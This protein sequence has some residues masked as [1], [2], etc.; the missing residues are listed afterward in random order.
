[1]KKKHESELIIKKINKVVEKLVIKNN[2]HVHDVI[3]WIHPIMYRKLCCM[4]TV[5]NNVNIGQSVVEFLKKNNAFTALTG[6]NLL[7]NSTE[8]HYFGN[9]CSMLTI[10]D[11]IVED[12]QFSREQGDIALL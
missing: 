11:I 8:H 1:M 5:I 7:I 4:N 3:L 6:R 9:I 12:I 2:Y 10:E